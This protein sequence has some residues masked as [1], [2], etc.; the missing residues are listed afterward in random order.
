MT[1]LKLF[2]SYKTLALA[3]AIACFTS[4]ESAAQ[5]KSTLLN[6]KI[7]PSISL[8]LRNQATGNRQQATGKRIVSFLQLGGRSTAGE[9]F[10]S[11]ILVSQSESPP[12]IRRQKRD[13]PPNTGD[14][15]REVG[16]AGRPT[17]PIGSENNLKIT[18]LVP[19]TQEN[20][21]ENESGSTSEVVW[22]LTAEKYPTFWF[23]LPYWLTSKCYAEFVLEDETGA[24]VYKTT[25]SDSQDSHGVVGIKLPATEQKLKQGQWYQWKLLY[26]PGVTKPISVNGWVQRVELEPETSEEGVAFYEQTGIWYDPLTELAQSRLQAPKD[27][28]LQAEWEKLLRAINLEAIAQE[29]I[30]DFTDQ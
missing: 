13:N 19:I 9:L 16:G 28:E 4:Y 27:K 20:D 3:L 23:Y 7:S 25:L 21:Q 5:A 2:Q 14:T 22:G 29:P 24:E 8:P 15:N 26:Y 6:E 1:Y 11:N 12:R 30:L 18:A 10:N 17:C